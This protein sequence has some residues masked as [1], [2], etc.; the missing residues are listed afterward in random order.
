MA[1]QQALPYPIRK[2]RSKN[3]ETLKVEGHGKNWR[4]FGGHYDNSKYPPYKWD[5]SGEV[6][7]FSTEGIPDTTKNNVIKVVNKFINDFHLPLRCEDGDTKEE[8]SYLLELLE[9]SVTARGIKKEIDFDKLNIELTRIRHECK[10]LTYGIILIVDERKYEFL[11]TKGEEPAIYGC[12]SGYGLTILRVTHPKAVVH[13]F[14]HMCGLG[15][16]HG[17][18]STP[19]NRNC[20]MNW[21][22]PTEKFCEYCKNRLKEIWA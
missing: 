7:V 9:D 15:Y 22:Y 13:E 6:F 14:A 3:L 12:G 20:T 5:E 11:S 2:N 17:E 19:P 1:G 16:H 4:R 18:G 8:R 21:V 10:R